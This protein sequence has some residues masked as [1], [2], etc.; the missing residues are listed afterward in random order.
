[1]NRLIKNIFASCLWT[2]CIILLF[3][4]GIAAQTTIGFRINGATVVEKDT[5]TIAV[6]A[7]SLLTNKGVYSFRFGISYNS[8]YLEFINIDSVGSVLQTWGIPTF[9]KKTPGKILIAGAGTS[10]L[11]GNG[12]LFYL[13]FKALRGGGTNVSNIAGESYLNEGNPLLTVQNGYINAAARSYPDI[14]PDSYELYIGQEAQLYVSGGEAPF[15]YNVVDTAV[16]VISDQSKIK[17]KGPGLTKAFVTDKNGEVSYMSGNIDVRAIKMSILRS[18]AWPNDTFFVPVKIEIAPGT[19]VYSGYFEINYNTNVQGIKQKVNLGDYDISV[20]SNTSGNVNRVSFASSTG[21]T[22]SGIL[23]YL[24]FKAVNSGNHWFNFQNQKFD[25]KLLAFTYSEYVEVYYLPNLNISPNS[26]T[27][28][29]GTTEKINVTNGVPPM[30]YKSSNPLVATIDILGN[31]TGLSGGIVTVSATD[32]H[33]A[34]KTSGDFKILDNNFSIVNSDGV[35][36]NVTRVPVSTSALPG[37]KLLF[38]FEGVVTYNVNQ[39]DFIGIEPVDGS[40]ITE[41]AKSGNT[42]HVVGATSSGINSGTI[43]YLRFQLKNTVSLG[44]QVTVTLTSMKGNEGT[45]FSTVSSGKIT[46]VEQLSYRPVAKAGANKSVLEGEVVQLDGSGSYDEDNSPSPITYLWVAPAGIT[47]S[48]STTAKPTF[49]APE[50][51]ANKIFTFKLVVNDGESDSDTSKVSITVLQI[52]KKPVANAGPDKSYIEGS[53]VSLDGSLSYDPDLDV[54]SYKWTSLDGIILFDATSVSPSFIAPQVN[55]DKTYRFKLEVSDAAMFS[56]PDTVNIT[57]LQI[58]KKP[59]AFA[60]GDQTV[61]EGDPVQLDGSLSSDADTDPITFKW[62]APAIVTLSS[63]TVSKPTFTAPLVYR[64]SIIVIALVVNDGKLNSDTDKVSITIKNLNILSSRARILSAAV[65]NADSVKIDSVAF[66]VTMFMPYGTDIKSLAPTFVISNLATI[67][68]LSGSVRNFTSPVNYTVTAEDGL[69]KKAYSVRVNVPTISL[70]RNLAAGWNWISLGVIPPDLK[71]SSVLSTLTLANL[72]YIKSSTASAVYYSA[73]GWFGD[74]SDLPQLGMLMFNKATSQEFILTGKEINPALTTIPVANGWNRIGYILK[75]NAKLSEAFDPAS[76]PSGDI[77]LKSKEASAVYYP[78]S[79]WAGDLDSMRVLTGYMMKTSGSTNLKYKAGS[80]KIKSANYQLFER[81]NLY[82]SYKINPPQFENSANLIGEVV[83]NTSENIIGQ[84][85]LLIAYEGNK[86]RGVAE[87]VYIPDLKRFVFIL[88]MFSNTNGEAI[89]FKYK[90][91]SSGFEVELNE[92]VVFKSDEIFGSP[93][94]PLKLHLS[95]ATA[96]I[97]TGMER[98]VLVYPNPVFDKLQI[99]SEARIETI[100]LS[101]LSGNIVQ[102]HSNISE[103]NG[104]LNTRS[105]VPGIYIL[106]V[107]TTGGTAIRKL[108]K[109]ANR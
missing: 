11:T 16:A 99:I 51:N 5:F 48:S 76:L 45:L 101:G 70:K 107:E 60:G 98:S 88:S 42:A 19:R 25:E 38:D 6:R 63:T 55:F 106:K 66:T 3:Q 15:I 40:M 7:D 82:A 29:W 90:S 69:T 47:L 21:I 75:G 91:F 89:K 92:G 73:S 14:Y 28:M 96:V 54:I 26:G 109:S 83:S 81:N 104:V 50:V 77:L 57:V 2:S 97:E 64:D 78:A 33:G 74:L 44:Q 32:T 18:S 20:E 12:N 8:S 100:T 4:G 46:R 34:T 105:L 95:N 103:H 31:L 85:D 36:D 23:C 68:P 30:T 72:D 94:N 62:I 65:L 39:L 52:N 37:G 43:C 86:A 80:A 56:S 102:F 17:A 35:L 27:M 59:V 58:N 93:M 24:G 9:S 71:V 79:G 67:S 22:G 13:K 53:S 49:T 87:A 1:M 10:P 41:Y 61:N 108:I 84:G